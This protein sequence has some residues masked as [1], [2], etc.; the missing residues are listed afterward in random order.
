M[1]QEDIEEA[2]ANHAAE[3]VINCKRKHGR[4]RQSAALG[5]VSQNQK[6]EPE[7]IQMD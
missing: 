6:P 5:E 4:K 7:V 2:Q 3:D 1:S